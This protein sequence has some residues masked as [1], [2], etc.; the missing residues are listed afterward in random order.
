MC[1][2]DACQCGQS[3]ILHHLQLLL[4]EDY[5]MKPF[6]KLILLMWICRWLTMAQIMAASFG[7]KSLSME[8]WQMVKELERLR[9]ERLQ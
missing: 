2:A 6:A 3:G 9:K 8:H 7:E 5:E 4:H 1:A